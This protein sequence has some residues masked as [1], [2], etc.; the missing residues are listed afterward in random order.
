MAA[1]EIGRTQSGLGAKVG[2]LGVILEELPPELVKA[3]ARHS[4]S[5]EV[6]TLSPCFAHYD[7]RRLTKLD[8]SIPVTLDGQTFQFSAYEHTFS[9]TLIFPG[10]P[11]VVNFKMVYFWDEWQLNWTNPGAIYPDDPQVALK[12]FSSMAQAM[13]AYI[14]QHEFHTVHLHDYHVGLVP[15]FLGDDYLKEIPVH[16]TVHNASYQGMIPLIGAGGG[17]ATLDRVGLP[18][19]K[20]FHK[21]FDLFSELNLMKAC[22]LRVHEADGHVTTVSGDLDATWGYA[23]ELKESQAQL[24]ARAWAQK[25]SRPID[26]F[27]PN[28][29][30]DLFE[31]IPILGITNGLSD[32]NRPE[33]LPE[34]KAE[35]LRAA[36]ARRGERPLF[37]NAVTQLEMLAEDHSFDVKRLEIKQQLHRLLYL[38]A[39]GHESFGQPLIFTA[40]G[41]LVEQKNLGLIGDVIPRVLAYDNQAKFVIL[42]SAA[43]GDRH[44]MAV[45]HYFYHLANCYPGRVYFNNSF[46]QPLSRLILSGGDFTLVPSRFEPC[47]LVDYEAALLGTIPIAR[48]TGGLTKIS[49]CGY[50]YDWLDIGD[51]AGEANAFYWKMKE[52]IDTFRY[53][54]SHHLEL[55]RRAMAT[56]TNWD[57]SADQYIEM[58]RCGTLMKQWRAECGNFLHMFANSLGYERNAFGRFFRPEQGLF[59][60]RHDR[61]L[62][63]IL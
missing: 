7:K 16:F 11:R 56:N 55:I 51:R 6:V 40:V 52:A 21:Y 62:K 18:G 29:G 60:D 13:A 25:G 3:A 17:Y 10:G 31:K 37:A 9:D 5:L 50:L 23:A 41:R 63:Q 15:L 38:E 12:L 45:E 8:I 33:N 57:A 59:A 1:W 4:L 2:G 30:L 58:Y 54:P 24:N 28:R 44:G 32:N 34:L 26:V 14:T 19:E 43:D 47:G 22:M 48:A 49:H 36:Q 61:D 42:A 53:N 46:N 27:L 39:F 20:L 35:V